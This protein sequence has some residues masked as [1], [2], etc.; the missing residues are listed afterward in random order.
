VQA[1]WCAGEVINA[2]DRLKLSENTLV[3]FSSDNGPV[4]DDG[5][6][7]DA[8]KKLGDHKPSGPL[9]GGKYSKFEAGT[10][11]PCIVRWPGRVKPGVSDAIVSQVDFLASFAALSGQKP[12]EIDEAPDTLNV[13][14]ALLGESKDG[15]EHVVLQGN[16]LALRQGNWKYIEPTKGQR[17]NQGTRTELGN[18]AQPQLYDLSKDLAERSNVVE[19]HPERVQQMK[20]LLEKIRQGGQTPR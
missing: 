10:R 20:A 13:L 1:D 5:Y 16:G 17:V 11:V 9:R 3:I 14:P 15:R 8:I 18:D 2:L 6:E 4:I 19:Q 7:D 12:A